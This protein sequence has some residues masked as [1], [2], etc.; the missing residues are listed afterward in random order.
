MMRAR[1]AL[2]S[3]FFVLF[4]LAAALDA[5]LAVRLRRAEAHPAPAPAPAPTAVAA[6]PA[7]DAVRAELNRCRG[8][9][10]S[11]LARAVEA[12]RRSPRTTERPAPAPSGSATREQQRRTLCDLAEEELR[13]KWEGQRDDLTRSLR[14]D[15]RDQDEQQK[16][17]LKDAEKLASEIGVDPAAQ[18][19]LADAYLPMRRARIAA[20]AD[21]LDA[22][23]PDYGAV[24]D[25]AQGLYAD[26]DAVVGRLYGEDAKQRVRAAEIRSR[27]AIVAIAASMAGA[28]WDDSIVW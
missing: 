18:Q 12:E 11:L 20:A 9:T 3:L 7:C 23:P 1:P 2:S 15:L 17:A 5:Y 21:A 16:Q 8:D 19:A 28:P 13:Q 6:A 4:V 27:T 10:W 14:R 24:L 22:D 25:A 26:E